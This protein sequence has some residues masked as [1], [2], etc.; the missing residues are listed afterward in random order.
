MNKHIFL[1]CMNETGK[2]RNKTFKRQKH[3]LKL[4]TQLTVDVNV[5]N[6]KLC[7]RVRERNF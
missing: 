7:V 6:N 2:E 5:G 3:Q 4:N 1:V